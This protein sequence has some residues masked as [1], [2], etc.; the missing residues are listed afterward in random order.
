[1]PRPPAP[2]NGQATAGF[3]CGLVGL[4]ICLIPFG[5]FIGGIVAV[6]GIVFGVLGRGRARQV[7]TGQGMATAGAVMGALAL[8]VGV[9][10]LIALG[11]ILDRVKKNIDIRAGEFAVSPESCRATRFGTL[12]ASGTITNTTTFDKVFVTVHV[13]VRNSRG[14]I[15]GSG[16]DFV[17]SVDA[18][19]TQ[20]Y[21]VKVALDDPSVTEPHCEVT[22]D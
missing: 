8:V 1:M 6:V 20:A 12:D 4:V 11:S 18:H 9:V 7:G 10:W 5:I 21:L 3:V 22:V 14:V 19:D 17:G 16:D 13:I 2:S 15:V